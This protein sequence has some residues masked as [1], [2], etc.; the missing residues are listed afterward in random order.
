MLSGARHLLILSLTGVRK[1][2]KDSKRI[3]IVGMGK[4]IRRIRGNIDGV[5]GHGP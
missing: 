2:R 5:F 3:W 1:I 4:E